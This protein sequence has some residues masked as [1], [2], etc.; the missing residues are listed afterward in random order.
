MTSQDNS[1]TTG[2][3][4]AK[5]SAET[6]VTTVGR[7][8]AKNY[9][10]VNPP[11][12]RGSTVLFP[13]MKAFSSYDQEYTYGRLGA[14]TTRALEQA[15]AD[16]EG[17]GKSWLTPSGL[18]AITTALLAFA[19]TGAHFLVTDSVYLPTRRFCGQVLHRLG[20][21][22][23]YYDPL[24]G[25]GVRELMK[26]NTR[27]V[28]AE[29]PGS[30]TFEVQDIPAL[31]RAAHDHGAFVIIDNTWATPLYFQP[32]AHGADVSIQALTKYVV[33]HADAM[34]GAITANERATPFVESCHRGIGQCA[35]PDDCYLALRGLRTL[36]VR[37]ER[38]WDS[39][40][41]MARW[42]QTRAEVARVMHPA[43]P[44]DAGHALWRRDF[45]GAS[46]LFA[47]VLK[48]VSEQALSIMLDG[49]ERFGMGYSWGG[50][51][52]LATPFTPVRTAT[53][54]SAEG[55]ALRLHIGLENT[56]DLKA[57]L[58]RG[59]ARMRAAS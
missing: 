42:L 10:F 2:A 34:L 56:E 25:E 5:L 28:F 43:L 21:E 55:P 39:G 50:Y 26:P 59:F 16:L 38:H 46:G 13:T 51:E 49:L 30:L 11:I 32:F 31:C 15:L 36:A 8:P 4:A 9:G 12:Y 17:G 35:S 45:L 58:Q 3:R 18:S 14:P 41:E 37:L 57:D 52:S 1:E 33:G 47:I 23:E 48:P 6:R 20:V 7:D 24:I 29:S 53:K 22:V 54:W 40:M 19:E 44:G 27:V